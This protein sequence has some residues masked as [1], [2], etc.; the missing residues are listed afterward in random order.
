[1]DDDDEYCGRLVGAGEYLGQKVK[2]LCHDCDSYT[3]VAFHF[4]YLKVS[5]A[6]HAEVLIG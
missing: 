3:V 6:V 5:G 1:M 4:I 2:V